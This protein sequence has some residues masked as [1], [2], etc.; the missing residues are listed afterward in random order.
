MKLTIFKYNSLFIIILVWM[1]FSVGCISTVEE[2]SDERIVNW[3]V[4]LT[5]KGGF[6][7]LSKII[8][9]SDGLI[10]VNGIL[11]QKNCGDRVVVSENKRHDILRLL[12]SLI[13][14]LHKNKNLNSG[15]NEKLKV[16]YKEIGNSRQCRDCPVIELNFMFDGKRFKLQNNNYDN[17]VSNYSHLQ[18]LVWTIEKETR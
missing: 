16:E 9:N 2:K 10:S 13:M 17:R 7:G 6:S 1:L 11:R 4:E 5:T 14:D 8:I 12:K 18:T 15:H 3:T